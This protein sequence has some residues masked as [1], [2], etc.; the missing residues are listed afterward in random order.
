[1]NNSEDLAPESTY[2]LPRPRS[3]DLQARGAT[4]HIP[5]SL[6]IFVSRRLRSFLVRSFAQRPAQLLHR[7]FHPL[8][9]SFAYLNARAIRY[10]SFD[11]FVRSGIQC[12]FPSWITWRHQSC[13][14]S[15]IHQGLMSDDID[16]RFEIY[17]WIKRDFRNNCI[18]Q[19]ETIKW[20]VFW[21]E[22]IINGCV[23]WQFAHK[24]NCHMNLLAHMNFEERNVKKWTVLGAW[25][26]NDNKH[27]FYI[28]SR[29]AL[30]YIISCYL[31]IMLFILWSTYSTYLSIKKCHI[32]T[33]VSS[34]VRT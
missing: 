7:P 8:R 10:S 13:L 20:L 6:R 14:A 32:S 34:A 28:T 25:T 17:S 1:M 24:L 33:Y 19:Y 9:E 12:A 15:K 22:L 23:V 27:L 18:W 5:Q 2:N 3:P 4:F 16:A 31:H 29:K 30:F 26:V 21:K 11:L